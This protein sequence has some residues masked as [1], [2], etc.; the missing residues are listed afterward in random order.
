M[1]IDEQGILILSAS[2]SDSVS[3]ISAL[4]AEVDN[5]IDVTP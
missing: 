1:I 2:Q 4:L 5:D 3:W